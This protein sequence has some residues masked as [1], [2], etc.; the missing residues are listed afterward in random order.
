MAVGATRDLPHG[1]LERVLRGRKIVARCGKH[2]NTALYE[3][4]DAG[5]L[6]NK[7]PSEPRRILDQ[8]RSDP[9]ALDPIQ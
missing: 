4:N 2:A 7:L 9:V 8:D 1:D 6:D 3:S 5:L